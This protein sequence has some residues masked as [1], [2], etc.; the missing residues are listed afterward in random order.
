MNLRPLLSRLRPPWQQPLPERGVHVLG[1]EMADGYE[2]PSAS[3]DPDVDLHALM[4]GIIA[5]HNTTHHPGRNC[6]ED[7]NGY[8][9]ETA[10]TIEETP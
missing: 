3:L 8:C 4:D 1:T 10:A 5:D 6:A 7:R 2:P 9:A